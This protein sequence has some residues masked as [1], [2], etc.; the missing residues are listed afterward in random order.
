VNHDRLDITPED[1]NRI[2]PVAPPVRLVQTAHG[3]NNRSFFVEGNDRTYFLKRYDNAPGRERLAAE[4]RLISAVAA[5]H[6]PF[7]VPETIPAQTGE[8]VV[9]LDGH[10]YA[11]SRFI[12]GNAARY[13]DPEDAAAC[14]RALAE[15]H[16]ALSGT[17]IGVASGEGPGAGDLAA[18]H[19]LIPEPGRAVREVLDDSSLAAEASAIIMENAKRHAT[20]T[21][22][23]PV[24][25]I[26]W[27]YYPSNVLMEEH[28]VTGIL[29]FEFAGAGYWAMDLAIGLTA[30]ALGHADMSLLVDRFAGGYFSRRD[31]SEDEITAVPVLI[32]ERDARSLVH[33]TGRFRQGLTDRTE[34]A[35]RARRL[36]DLAGFLD[37]HGPDLVARL[38]EISF[39]QR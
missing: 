38:H 20:I 4:S 9:E 25:W 22:G 15:L 36:I 23:W 6:P 19:P 39:R 29:D 14:G 11:L 16:V 30:F 27:D 1:V 32:L 12:R 21:V 7:S 26:H 35:G 8:I 3:M 37:Q 5:R 24:S 28:R 17:D 34:I 33:W 18:V 13:G 10:L 31:V 2:W